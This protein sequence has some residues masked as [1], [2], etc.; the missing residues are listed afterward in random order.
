MRS[1]T[2]RVQG[3]IF[4]RLEMIG[5]GCVPYA[6]SPPPTWLQ[7]QMKWAISV[8]PGSIHLE[9]LLNCSTFLPRGKIYKS[10]PN[11]AKV[12][13]KL[14]E[15]YHFL[16]QPSTNG[17]LNSVDK[18]EP[19]ILWRDNSESQSTRFL[20]GLSSGKTS[21]VRYFLLA[22]P[23]PL[24]FF[25]LSII[26]ASWHQLPIKLPCPKLWFGETQ[27]KV[28]VPR[29][30]M[31]NY[32]L[33]KTSDHRG[34]QTQLRWWSELHRPNILFLWL[35]FWQPHL[36]TTYLGGWRWILVIVDTW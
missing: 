21:S 15:S 5:T 25:S 3:I 10:S 24:P 13:C 26:S 9:H 11:T 36:W 29:I 17:L 22:F 28:G 19:L 32:V 4:R 6:T 23:S 30:M 1:L 14:W 20:R 16:E 35:F 31:G 12:F 2:G 7:L 27:I 18:I 34:K 33:I 8:H